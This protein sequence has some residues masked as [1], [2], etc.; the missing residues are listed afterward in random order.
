MTEGVSQR[1]LAGDICDTYRDP[2]KVMNCDYVPVSQSGYIYMH[3]NCF[4]QFSVYFRQNQCTSLLR[5]QKS[6]QKIL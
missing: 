3:F 2:F 4:T 5:P 6:S 1:T